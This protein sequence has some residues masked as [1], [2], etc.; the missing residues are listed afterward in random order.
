LKS[1]CQF[2]QLSGTQAAHFSELHGYEMVSFGDYRGG[3]RGA[4]TMSANSSNAQRRIV[5]AAMAI[6]LT[7]GIHGG[8]LGGMDRDAVAVTAHHA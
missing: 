2:E 1:N 8:W 5:S 3:A 7:V 4:N 6:V